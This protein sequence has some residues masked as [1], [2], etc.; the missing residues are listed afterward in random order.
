MATKNNDMKLSAILT[1]QVG[2]GDKELALEKVA[3]AVKVAERAAR[4]EVERA[5]DKLENLNERYDAMVNNAD[6]SLT[7]L[8]DMQ[9]EIAV[10][11]ADVDAL[12]AMQSARF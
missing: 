3:K 2:K 9:R 7:Q 6:T 1:A 12:K 10:A 4:A 11:A 5:E 8:V